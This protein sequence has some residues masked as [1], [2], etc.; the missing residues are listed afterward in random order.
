MLPG[1]ELTDHVSVGQNYAVSDELEQEAQVPLTCLPATRLSRYNSMPKLRL[2]GYNSK[3]L[4][5]GFYIN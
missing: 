1:S 3:D 2:S 4:N 5:T